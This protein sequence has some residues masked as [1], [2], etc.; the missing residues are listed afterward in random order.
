MTA[1]GEP[2]TRTDGPAKVTGAARYAADWPA[3]G[4]LHAVII[5]AGIARGQ[6][7][8]LD[9][10]A[11]EAAPGVV[12]VFTHH[13]A[14]RLAPGPTP[15][16]G[17]SLLPLQDNRVLYEGQPV[18]V[19]VADRLERVQEAAALIDVDYMPEA[20][21]V[22]FDLAAG[23][24]EAPEGPMVFFEPDGD[25]GDVQAGARGAFAL[26][27]ETYETASRHHNPIEPSATLAEWR[28][29]TLTLHD[30]TQGVFNVRAGVA[31][32]LGLEPAQVRVICHYTGGGFGCKGWVWPHELLAA[33]IARAVGGAVRLVLSRA[34]A[35][36]SHGYQ[37]ATRQRVRI[38]AEK[39]GTLRAV[40]HHAINATSAYEHYLE[41]AV[42]GTRTLYA[43]P[44]I[45]TRS[46]VAPLSTIT[47]T[48]MRAPHEGP[49][50]FALESAI[51]ELAGKLGID[52]LQLR[53]TNHAERDP[54]TDLPFS[55]KELLACYQQGA[56]RFGWSQRPPAPRSTREG[57]EL[58]G[59]GMASAI[60][61]TFRQAAS[62][63]IALAADGG[64]HV[65]T[66]SQE[67][68]TGISTIM[69]QITADALACPA[70][71][72]D[73][74]LGD[75]NFPEAGMTAG[76]ST[77]LSVGA[78]VQRSAAQLRER[79]GQLATGSEAPAR[80]VRIEGDELVLDGEHPRRE[81]LGD[82][83]ARHRITELTAEGQWTPEEDQ[84]YSMHS[85][86]AIFCQARVDVD[87]GLVRV[88]RL[89]GAY[90]A[91]RIINP[92][93]ARSQ[94]L[95]GMTWGIGQALLERSDT[96]TDHGRFLSKNL[97]GYLVPCNADILDI[98]V[99]FADEYD[100]H[101][102]PTGARGL[103]EV[104]A[105]GVSAAIANAIHH[106]TGTRIRRLPITPEQLIT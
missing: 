47:P 3:A 64:V 12:A 33:M 72:V 61:T 10:S 62:A 14:P 58:V 106:A 84:R 52:P 60:M 95:G 35:F 18:A 83:F 23:N 32:T 28:D 15:P 66:G 81:R 9:T 24:P 51:D 76:S 13:N 86:G 96:D 54:T 78:A 27:D 17:T 16:L 19:V 56:E 71:Q 100:P 97:A 7:A 48:P 104:G 65:Q 92:V 73:V 20:A 77:T 41:L 22:D 102:S 38:A 63:R 8:A 70:G 53:I 6:I 68:G 85:Y 36:T 101:A 93:T 79:L 11:A 39:D 89:L 4:L 37:P 55:S 98:E 5:G 25:V 26:L 31:A 57:N 99:I 34:Q 105:T 80:E 103:G 42:A 21:V 88:S 49:G 59:W 40:Y 46:Q 50:L 91:G 29:E 1:V 30:S 94:I 45:Q 69:G 75:T 82:L 90:S 74:T 67:I 2:R 44:N 43:C 87:L